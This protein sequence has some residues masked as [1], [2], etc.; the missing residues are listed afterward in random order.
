MEHPST[1]KV[2]S[3]SRSL[4]IPAEVFHAIKQKAENENRSF[5]YTAVHLLRFALDEQ[6]KVKT[7]A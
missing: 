5:N 6:K 1:V 7:E 4:Q 3:I 2:P